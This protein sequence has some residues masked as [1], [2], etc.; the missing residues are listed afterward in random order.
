MK[1]LNSTTRDTTIPVNT[2]KI[3]ALNETQEFDE[4]NKSLIHI[5]KYGGGEGENAQYESMKMEMNVFINK[6]Y[7]AI[8]NTFKTAYWDTHLH[9][10]NIDG[11]HLGEGIETIEF[12]DTIKNASFDEMLKYIGEE[13]PDPVP[14]KNEEA[15]GFVRHVWYDFEV[16]RRYSAMRMD[17]LDN[18]LKSLNEKVDDLDCYFAETMYLTTTTQDS[19]GTIQTT[20]KSV[21]HT[22]NDNDIYCQMQILDGNKISNEWTVPEDGNLVIYG[23]LDSS[24]ALDNKAI[25]TSYCVIEAKINNEWEIIGAQGVIPA[26]SIT[27]VGFN[28]LVH[29]NLVIRARTGFTVGVKSSQYSNAQDGNDTLS[30]STANGFKCMVYSSK[31]KEPVVSYSEQEDEDE[32]SEG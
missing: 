32:E 22:G 10:N 26:K 23:W 30:N 1:I 5:V 11:I 21:N 12:N 14:F 31:S 19:N 28:L 8:Q 17:Y 7:Q 25:P 18:Q 6:V 27:Y 16:L 15:D 13:A 4:D 2:T 20:H 9:E 24:S 3:S 29:K